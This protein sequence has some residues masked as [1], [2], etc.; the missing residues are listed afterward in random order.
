MK[1]RALEGELA[2]TLVVEARYLSA[3]LTRE[4][5]VAPGMTVKTITNALRAEFRALKNP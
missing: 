3:W 4:H 5:P 2:A 1:R